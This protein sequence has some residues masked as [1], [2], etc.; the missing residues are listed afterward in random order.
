MIASQFEKQILG[1]E[2]WLKSL[3]KEA[4]SRFSS[5]GFPT[6][7][8]EEWKYTNVEPI[9]K[10]PFQFLDLNESS[11]PSIEQNHE[12]LSARLV[13][14]NGHYV[15]KLSWTKGLVPGVLAGS[16]RHFLKEKREIVEAHL[17]R[18]ASFQNHSFVALNTAFIQD[19][20]F[21]YLPHGMILDKPIEILFIS[22]GKASFVSQ[23]RNLI[24]A[25]AL[26]QASIIEQYQG[27]ASSPYFTNSVT[28]IFAADSAI[29][30]HSK[31]QE[32]SEKAYH[33]FSLGVQQERQSKVT[34]HSISLGAAL[35][36]H[37]LTSLLHAEGGECVMNGL[38]LTRGQQHVDHHTTIDHAKAHC[39]SQELYKGILSGHSKGVFNGRVIVRPHAKKTNSS[40]ANKNLLLSEGAEIDTQPLLEIFNNDVKCSHGATTGRLDPKQIFYLKSRG[41]NDAFA[42]SLLSYAFASEILEK[43]KF[44][45]LKTKLQ[46]VLFDRLMENIREELQ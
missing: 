40:Q 35:S 28:E 46:T 20:A 19:G 2:P 25:E 8:Q 15:E 30:E 29:I 45:F 44:N 41:I 1:S 32:E 26:S 11:F 17:S 13:F 39:V 7:K 24:V 5:L 9:Q 21:I 16:L 14:L 42:K 10:L 43:L 31:I 18:Y 27:R 36:R 34:S 37:D 6:L 22:E 4:M 23:P 12:Q 3:Q 38:Y 33:I